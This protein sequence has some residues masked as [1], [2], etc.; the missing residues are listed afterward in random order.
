M[1]QA[2]QI[3]QKAKHRIIG[4]TIETRPE[5]VTDENLRFWRELGVTRVE[6]GVQSM[7][8]DVLEVNKR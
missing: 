1:Q 8:D 7:F 3:N 5:Y 6:M 4:L 2:Q